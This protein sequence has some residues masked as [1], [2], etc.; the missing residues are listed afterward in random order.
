MQT[1]KYYLIG[2]KGVGMAA[3]AK[4]L[5]ESG[6][7]V[8][9]SDNSDIYV[10]DEVLARNKI[11]VLSPF[12]KEN[13]KGKHPD[14]VVVSAA[15]DSN[16][17]EVKEAK[18]RNL[19]LSYYADALKLIT[20]HK[21][22]IAV[23]GIHGKTTI[24]SMMALLLKRASLDPSYIIGAA[25]VPVLGSNAHFGKGEYFVLEADEYRKSPEDNDSKFLSLSPE[26]AIISSIELDHPDIFSCVED[27]YHAFF[28]FS[29]RVAR[30]GTIILN[31]DYTKTKKLIHSLADRH[32]ETYGFDDDA[33]W[34][35]ID[36]IEGEKTCFSI[37][38]DKIILGPYALSMPGKHNISNAA[39]VVILANILKIS[40][41]V[42]KKVL[43]DFH[44]VERRFEKI[45]QIDDINIYD[46]YA[47]HP[48]A[49]EKTLEATK[50]KFPHSKIW[51]IFQ[52]HTYSRTQGLLKEFGVSFKAAD[53]IIIT[54]IY[55]SAREGVGSVTSI[56][57]VNEIKKNKG[58][59]IYM[60]D[61]DKI[62]KYLKSF[63]KSPAVILT[64]GA[65]DIYKFS[66]EIPSIFKDNKNG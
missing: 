14:F 35:I 39:T 50:A 47:H 59:V 53:K 9:G 8:E 52:P 23:A 31:I 43:L 38:H 25:N 63:V 44:G 24:T 54:D 19:N 45:D 29:C 57:L 36:V 26:I 61:W 66:H 32:F 41:T 2:I 40:N 5:V 65:G 17:V 51:C 60:S 55:A 27:I 12:G 48:T 6:Q 34:Q 16:N 56:D 46:D 10:T 4:Y 21:K 62:K 7:I 15:Y 37:K 13:L 30:T 11:K 3:L 64:L 18:K 20:E 28:R 22:L 1:N 58:S 49:I 42:V 33:D